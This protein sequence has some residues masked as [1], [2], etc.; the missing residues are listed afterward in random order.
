VIDENDPDLK[1][2]Q[3]SNKSLTEEEQKKLNDFLKKHELLGEDIKTSVNKKIS[4]GN[5]QPTYRC[6]ICKS[7]LVYN[8]QTQKYWCAICKK[9]TTYEKK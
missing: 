5:Y 1:D 3:V 2:N 6:L 8:P 4:V 7:S 9:E